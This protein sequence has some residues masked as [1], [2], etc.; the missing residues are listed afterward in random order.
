MKKLLIGSIL[1]A[2]VI[3]F[4]QFLSFALLNLHNAATDYTP[5]QTEVLNYLDSQFTESGSYYLPRTPNGASSEEMEKAMLDAQGKP[6]AIVSYHKSMNM[7]MGANMFRGIVINV[8]MVALLCGIVSKLKDPT[9]GQILLTSIAVG[10]I[11]FFNV[12]YTSHIWYEIFD[13]NA[14]LIDAIVGWGLVGV[15]VGLVYRRRA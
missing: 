3:F 15:V 1:G 6:W 2:I 12:P 9:F 7:S 8:I 14:Y 10:M 5:K 4:W 13:L 11:V